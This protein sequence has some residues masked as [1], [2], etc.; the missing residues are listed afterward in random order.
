MRIFEVRFKADVKI[1]ALEARAQ[2][3]TKEPSKPDPMRP[4]VPAP[5]IAVHLVAGG[6]LVLVQSYGTSPDKT[7][8]VLVPAVQCEWL[9]PWGKVGEHGYL[10]PDAQQ[11]KELVDG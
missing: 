7:G 1:A 3:M 6:T 8:A 4:I 10:V 5:G 9:K 11:L 2:F